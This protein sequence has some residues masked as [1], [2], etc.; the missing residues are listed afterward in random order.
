[1]DTQR[2]DQIRTESG[3][4]VASMFGV[5][6]GIISFALFPFLLPGIAILVLF[7]LPLVPLLIP[8]ILGIPVWL[9]VRSIARRRRRKRRA[10]ARRT[11]MRTTPA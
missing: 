2:T 7:A 5:G 11:E 4:E 6:L 1:M 9:A 3:L 8:V 10:P